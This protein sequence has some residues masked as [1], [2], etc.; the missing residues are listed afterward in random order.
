MDIKRLRIILFSFA[1]LM[2]FTSIF[3]YN[4][5]ESSIGM[6]PVIT[7]PYREYSVIFLILTV[8]FLSSGFLLDIVSRRRGINEK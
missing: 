4:F 3:T 7:Y 2:F 5:K 8:G 6:L 1:V